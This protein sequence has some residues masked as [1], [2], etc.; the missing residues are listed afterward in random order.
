MFL[1]P[2][3]L[4]I[5]IAIAYREAP[6]NVFHL[7][8]EYNIVRHPP[9][10]ITSLTAGNLIDAGRN[11]YLPTRPLPSVTFAIDWSRGGGSARPFQWTNLMIHGV[12]AIA[13][14]GLLVLVLHRINR[15]P[16]VIAVA[17][18]FG[19]AIWACHPIQVQG[20]TYVVQRMASMAALFTVLTVVLYILG[21]NADRS[22]RRWVFF[23]LAGLCWILGMISKETAA[24]APFLVL[25]AEFGVLRQGQA[26]VRGR[27]DSVML[28]LPVVVAVLIT[29]DILSGTGPL[30][31]NFLPGYE[32]RDFT[33]SERL[34]TQPRVIGFH[35]SQIF[36]PLPGRFSLEHDF[37]ASTGLLT[38][39]T[40]L[41]AML[42]VASWCAIGVWA[43]FRPSLRMMGFFLLWVPATLVI[44]STIIPLEMV[45]E[46]RM[47]L[48]SV[49]LA[50][51]AALVASWMLLRFSRLRPMTLTVCCVV[52][53][54]LVVSTSQRVP[55][56]QS[57]LSLAQDTVKN[58]PNSARAWAN[59]A[60]A[61]KEGGHGWDMIIPPLMRALALD[62]N[63]LG[64]LHIYAIRLIELRRLDEAEQ[65]LDGLAPR[66]GRDHSIVNTVG[67]LRFEQ[68]DLPG[69]IRQFEQ[70]I[71]LNEFVPE[72]RYNIAL[73]YELS[74]RC[75]EAREAWL[76]YLHLEPNE[77]RQSMIRARLTR[78]FDTQ[79]GRCFGLDR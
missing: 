48:P 79:G 4:L 35:F 7:D 16:W 78:N 55:V 56:W 45:F 57:T 31:G 39:A 41:V 72:F 40:T 59:L 70:A 29:L 46:H 38:P 53:L 2:V 18:L 63:H 26:I 13:V 27:L 14:F 69:A 52:V 61:F 3:A 64:A 30:A 19:A 67:M 49:G 66:A 24:I 44:E 34:L 25:L 23:I 76:S 42:G 8:D 6:N 17:A 58:A 62:P 1:T 73:S 5:L 65:I 9:V 37:A 75:R 21:R 47:D 11:A 28:S 12:A 43:L 15:P 74:G 32:N 20:V 50:G 60:N 71:R 51:L 33:L 77:K 22:G 68:G 10:M 54:L 36:W